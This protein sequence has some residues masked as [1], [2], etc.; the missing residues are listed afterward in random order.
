MK[1]KQNVYHKIGMAFLIWLGIIFLT[2]N[3]P[4][5]LIPWSSYVNFCLYFL[6]A[7]LAFFIFRADIY[8]KNIFLNFSVYFLYI[9]LQYFI[10]FIGSDNLFGDFHIYLYIYQ[11]HIIGLYFLKI[12]VVLYP[13]LLILFPKKPPKFIYLIAFSI[14]TPVI[15]SIYHGFF[16]DRNYLYQLGQNNF[17][18]PLFSGNIYANL[19]ILSIL[20]G[21]WL[22]YVRNDPVL[23][24]YINVIMVVFT[25]DVLID[26]LHHISLLYN[27]ELFS[28]GQHIYTGLLILLSLVL[29][30]KLSYSLSPFGRQ[31]EGVIQSGSDWIGRRRGIW[32]KLVRRFR[33]LLNDPI[34]LLINILFPLFGFSTIL[35]L[36][37]IQKKLIN[38]WT[39]V[40]A[41]MFLVVAITYTVIM[42]YQILAKRREKI[43]LL[44]K[45]A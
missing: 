17:Y 22:N 11:Y 26:T 1:I 20:L 33:H 32:F 23:G 15:F 4:H 29:F 34:V 7:I 24:E 36:N 5:K 42:I 31:Y 16:L 27:T 39:F 45:G 44:I 19:V 13:L 2:S 3:L 18:A 41:H 25:Y 21:F 43:G 40:F 12:L 6:A 10:S 28:L 38:P 35:Y 30:L 14:I 9:A 8:Y 37:V